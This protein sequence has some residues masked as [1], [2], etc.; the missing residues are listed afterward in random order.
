MLPPPR[1]K[2]KTEK[3]KRKEEESNGLDHQ[4]KLNKV[5]NSIYMIL[6]RIYL[7]AGNF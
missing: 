3:K 5:M 1:E 2:K 7:R 4:M 6:A